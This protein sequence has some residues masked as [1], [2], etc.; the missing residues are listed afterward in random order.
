MPGRV[1][2]VNLQIVL[3]YLYVHLFRLRQ[4]RHRRRRR[5]DA[6]A[7]LRNRNALDTV[8]PAL[9]LQPRVR[10][11]SLD[12]E[13]YFLERADARLV[14]I[15]HVRAPP[16][17]LR[18][19]RVHPVQVRREQSR[20]VAARAGAYLDDNVLVVVRILRHKRKLQVALRCL[21]ARLQLGDLLARQL[22]HLLVALIAQH[23]AQVVQL[24]RQ[25]TGGARQLDHL[26]Y[27][28]L[29]ARQPLDSSVVNGNIRIGHQPI[30]LIVSV[31]DCS[32][33]V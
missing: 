19:P 16:L 10:A 8:H 17:P 6:T 28:C 2:H 22:D 33:S 32:H 26:A 29:L 14:D 1:E 4:H 12:L 7:R 13:Y 21:V 15:H 3:V 5:V 9:V 27:L 11:L 20:L 24:R 23:L 18:V 31:F 25:R 30:Y